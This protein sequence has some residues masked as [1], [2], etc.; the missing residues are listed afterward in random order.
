[1][2]GNGNLGGVTMRLCLIYSPDRPS[3][4]HVWGGTWEGGER[5]ADFAGETRNSLERGSEAGGLGGYSYHPTDPRVRMLCQSA[6][7]SIAQSGGKS[8]G[9]AMQGRGVRV[10]DDLLSQQTLGELQETKLQ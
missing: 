4:N 2:G 1:M 7:S 8:W 9:K 5:N 10:R 3:S 6:S